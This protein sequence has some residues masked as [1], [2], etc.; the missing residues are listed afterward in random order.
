MSMLSNPLPFSAFSFK[1]LEGPSIKAIFHSTKIVSNT[2]FVVAFLTYS[3][4]M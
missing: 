3:I 4:Q 1:I 2:S